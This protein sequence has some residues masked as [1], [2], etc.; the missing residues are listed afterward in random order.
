MEKAIDIDFKE[1]YIDFNEIMQN[2]GEGDEFKVA[3]IK[4]TRK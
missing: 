2:G 3:G 1:C 4:S